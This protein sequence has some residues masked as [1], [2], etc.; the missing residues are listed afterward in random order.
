M[1]KIKEHVAYLA[2]LNVIPKHFNIL[3]VKCHQDHFKK[4]EDI[5]IPE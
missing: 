4:Y 3:L 2:L 5:A 1:H